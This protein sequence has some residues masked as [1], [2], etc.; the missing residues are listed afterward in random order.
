MDRGRND[1]R[2]LRFAPALPLQRKLKKARSLRPSVAQ[3]S[4]GLRL[5][6]SAAE[7]RS[8]SRIHAERE[9]DAALP[10]T[11]LGLCACFLSCHPERSAFCGVEGSR[12]DA[13]NAPVC[14][15]AAYFCCSMI[16]ART[17]LSRRGNSRSRYALPSSNS[18]P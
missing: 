11:G 15:T 5:V 14:R 9:L 8:A 17:S 13:F 18:F 1:Q 10:D 12:L 4:L 6:L 2:S 3:T 16:S 7:G